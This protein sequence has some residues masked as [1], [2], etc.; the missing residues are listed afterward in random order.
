MKLL[1]KARVGI[2][3]VLFFFVASCGNSLEADAKEAAELTQKS[4]K[5][6]ANKEMVKAEKAYAES[7]LIQQ[8]YTDNS[9]A[10]YKLYMTFLEQKQEK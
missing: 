4:L 1:K 10:F 2:V 7:K 3:L 8:K 6:A 5:Y 9:E